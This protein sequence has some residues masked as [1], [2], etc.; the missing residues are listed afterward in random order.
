MKALQLIADWQPKA[1]YTPTEQE[2]KTHRTF[3]SSSVWKNPR[4][5]IS[6][7][8]DPEIKPDEV[9]IQV[10]AVGICGS[11][12][13]MY[14]HDADG[15]VLY[16]GLTRFPNILGHEF[17]GRVVEVGKEVSS[18][19]KGDLV[20]AEEIQWCGLCDACRR[21]L[22]NHCTNMEELRFYNSRSNGTIYSCKSKILL[23][24][25]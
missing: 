15:Y 13:H 19:K 2:L 10:A 21:G 24:N 3:A 20:T 12:M 16:P 8:P 22:V 25:R 1:G 14:E 23:E 18:L 17:S 6:T 7:L 9:L 5:E 11:D 4:I